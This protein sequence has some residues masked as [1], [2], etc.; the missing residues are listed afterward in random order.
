MSKRTDHVRSWHLADITGAP[1]ISVSGGKAD[2][3][4][5]ALAEVNEPPGR[6]QSPHTVRDFF[7]RGR[8]VEVGVDDDPVFSSSAIEL[9][10]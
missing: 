8:C 4:A 1:A 5:H 3:A 7:R 2:M 9:P 6:A 10:R